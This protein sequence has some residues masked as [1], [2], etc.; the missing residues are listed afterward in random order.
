MAANNCVRRHKAD[1]VPVL[2]IFGAGI[3]KACDKQHG[4]VLYML[5]GWHMLG[6]WCFFRRLD[7]AAR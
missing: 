5:S 3:A 6:G 2:C 4:P 7:G 1:I